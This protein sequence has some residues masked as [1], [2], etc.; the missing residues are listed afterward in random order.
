M[1]SYVIFTI[2]YLPDINECFPSGLSPE[3]QHLAHICHDDANCTNTKGSYSCGCLVGHSGDGVTCEGEKLV[4][5]FIELFHFT[6]LVWQPAYVNVLFSPSG[7]FSDIDECSPGSISNEY[8]HLAHNC[9]SDSNCTNTKGSFYCTCKT[10]FSGDGVTCVGERLPM[11]N[12]S[13]WWWF[14]K[15]L[16]KGLHKPLVNL[17][18]FLWKWWRYGPL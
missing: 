6:F 16:E 4:W 9:H 17:V 7:W 11:F 1:S 2:F 12:W 14:Q 8:K 18:W 15:V 10:G 13:P 3:Y 5:Y